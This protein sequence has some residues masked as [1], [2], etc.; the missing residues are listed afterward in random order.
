[1]KVKS[2]KSKVP[3]GKPVF[4][5]AGKSQNG[6]AVLVAIVV[7][8]IIIVIGLA[9]VNAAFREVIF[10][11]TA[12]KSAE[13]FYVADSGLE[14]FYYWDNTRGLEGLPSAFINP[15]DPEK[16]RPAQIYCQGQPIT[17]SMDF[18]DFT[19]KEKSI[20]WIP[21]GSGI[22]ETQ[23]VTDG[24][25]D[26]VIVEHKDDYVGDEKKEF[27]IA[28]SWGFNTCNVANPQRVDRALQVEYLRR[29]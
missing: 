8:A 20:F 15:T 12:R 19:G 28:Q 26:V 14:C 23:P 5:G 21:T 3:E 25:C 9:I 29:R 10:A 17:V 27:V 18:S 24:P 4:Y 7:A 11:T 6:F 2:Q 22:G 1:M 16:P 13:S